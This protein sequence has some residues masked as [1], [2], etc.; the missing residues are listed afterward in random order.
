MQTTEGVDVRRLVM[1]PALV[2]LGVTLLR[3]FGELLDWAPALF[4]RQAGGG[5]ALVGIAWLVPVFG[6][7][8][9]FQLARAGAAAPR[10]GPA[11]GLTLG[12]FALMPGLGFVAARL[13]LATPGQFS[14]SGLVLFA[15]FSLVGLFVGLRAWPALGR[16]LLAYGVAARVPVVVVMLLAMLGDWKTHYD[17]PAPGMPEMGVFAKWF[18]IG[19]VPQLTI[20]L[21]FTVVF[22]TFFGLLAWLVVGRRRAAA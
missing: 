14:I 22:G 5:G 8:F 21:W 9:A 16:V 1:V 20:W 15:L 11:F 13:G 6:V 2:T 19:L 7:V 10:V 4:S 17:A 18:L 12:A 3:L